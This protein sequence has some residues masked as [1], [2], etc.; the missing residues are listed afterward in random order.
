MLERP[1]SPTGPMA[2]RQ[3]PPIGSYSIAHCTKEPEFQLVFLDAASLP[4]RPLLHPSMSVDIP[5]LRHAKGHL[6]HPPQCQ[7]VSLVC[8]DP[9][10]TE[11][12]DTDCVM[13]RNH[14]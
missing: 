12:P 6:P 8:G 9:E 10:W 2:L 1:G 13:S 14:L 11:L 5:L 4:S 7:N 3:Q